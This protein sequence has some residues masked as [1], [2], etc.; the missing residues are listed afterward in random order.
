M[1]G[2]CAIHHHAAL[3]DR[4]LFAFGVTLQAGTLVLYPIRRD[5]TEWVATIEWQ[6][7]VVDGL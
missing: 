7:A 3:D 4:A 2:C 5:P 1:G 6:N